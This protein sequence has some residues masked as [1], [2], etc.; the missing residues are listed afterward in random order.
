MVANSNF[1]IRGCRH[2]CDLLFFVDFLFFFLISVYL[3]LIQCKF[4]WLQHSGRRGN[5]Y[6]QIK[7]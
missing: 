7:V 4:P 1:D 2:G 5:K 6:K 3:F